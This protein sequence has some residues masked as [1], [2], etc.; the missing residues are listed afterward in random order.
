MKLI[1]LAIVPLV[2]LA[3]SFTL[4]INTKSGEKIRLATEDIVEMIFEEN[5]APEPVQLSTPVVKANVTGTNV[6]ISWNK[7][8]N[9]TAYEY[10]IDRGVATTTTENSITI[11]AESGNHTI[12]VIALGDGISYLDSEA[13]KATYM[14]SEHNII[15]TPGEVSHS[16][17]KV[18]F[19]PSD[20]NIEYYC[21][22]IPAYEVITDND[23]TKYFNKT[24]NQNAIKGDYLLTSDNL[25]SSTNYL[26]IAVVKDLEEIVFKKEIR[27]S[28]NNSF[29]P[30]DV[31]SVFAYGCD[32]N[33][34]WYDVDKIYTKAAEI[35]PGASDDLMCWACSVS[36][37]LQWWI[38]EYEKEF[39]HK[40]DFRYELPAKSDH[41]STP[42]MN[43]MVSTFYNDAYD[44]Y[45]AYNWFFI[46]IKNPA[47]FSQ[48]GHPLF[49]EDSPFAY[50]GFLE[51][52]AE[53]VQKYTT[54]YTAWEIFP[55]TDPAEK[56]EKTFNDLIYN[57]LE[58]GV[59]E[60]TVNNGN[61]SVICWGVDYVVKD[62]GT[63]KATRMYI[64]ENGSPINQINQIEVYGI[65]YAKG[66]VK[67]TRG[68]LNNLTSLTV[69]RSP[70]V[71]KL[72]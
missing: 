64:A 2:L 43:M 68:N 21:A 55:L 56:I 29:K 60:I 3:Q 24:E 39:G 8:E 66:D 49:K 35:W 47:T 28:D 44:A 42:I 7:V 6:T 59:V 5:E 19:S 17:I 26:A 31:G 20:A 18:T 4:V 22:L 30:G 12:T 1:Y 53:F 41:Y 72:P 14:Y 63:R 46:P 37:C 40:P 69:L 32:V 34:G 52:D 70:R 33:S 11:P 54:K 36:G 51:R 23:I 62:D 13:G 57:L 50:G 58:S 25:Q 65:E 67:F 61:H 71:V 9:A 15:I 45:K 10:S 48:D 16:S 38:D 27:T